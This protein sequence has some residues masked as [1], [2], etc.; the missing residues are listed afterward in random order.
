MNI[1]V[2]III[3]Y[4]IVMI[5]CGIAGVMLTKNSTDFMVAGRNLRFWMYFPCLSTVI[6]GGGA[7]FGAARLSY[8]HGV[9]GAWV[10]VMYGLGIATMGV[11]LSS[12]LANLRVISISEMLEKR[13]SAASRYISALISTV[14]AA[15]LSVVQVIAIG[16]VLKSFFGWDMTCSMLIG[17][18]VC[19]LYTLLGGMWSIT[20]TDVLQFV[21]MIVGIFV[22]LIPACF[23]A[24][25]GVDKFVSSVP[26]SFFNPVAI[27]WDQL[28]MY[29]LLMYLGIM[30]GQDIWQRI[31]TAKNQKVAKRGTISAGFFS[32]LWGLAM[33]VCGITAYI[34]F[35]ALEHPQMALAEV[36]V[37]VI[38]RPYRHGGGGAFVRAYV[39]LQRADAGRLH[40]Y[41]KRP[42]Q[43]V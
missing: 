20:I 26:A 16:T 9:S 4:F 22:F 28:L 6:I 7:T 15:M 33:A 12:K 2:M 27:G 30:I 31:F 13:Y 14:Y 3:I 35:P 24:V 21:L 17:G 42:Y 5:G 39:V 32:V 43:T 18:C 25:G 23:K 10:T 36:V 34:L 8:E 11:L 19:M 29:F 37:N 41:Y 1:D 38:H 40:P